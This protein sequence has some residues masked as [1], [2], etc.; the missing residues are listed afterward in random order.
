MARLCA[1]RMQS[2]TTALAGLYPKDDF[3][4]MKAEEV[5][6]CIEDLGQLVY[7]TFSE[8]DLDTKIAKRKELVEGKLGEKIAALN[9][10]LEKNGKKMSVSDELSIA[11]IHLYAWC[12]LMTSGWLDGIPTDL[13]AKHGKITECCKAV[14]EHPKVIAWNEARAAASN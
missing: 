3:V 13:F 6:F 4:G 14:A 5:S 12:T 11:D 8:Q 2:R 7:A 1:S 10:L 9:A